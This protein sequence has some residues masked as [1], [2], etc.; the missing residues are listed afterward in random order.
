MKDEPQK[1]VSMAD[2]AIEQLSRIAKSHGYEWVWSDPDDETKWFAERKHP[3]KDG[4]IQVIPM[5]DLLK[6]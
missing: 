1:V 4:F 2:G 6:P 3:D 5:D